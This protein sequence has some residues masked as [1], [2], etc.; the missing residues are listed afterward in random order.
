MHNIRTTIA[1]S[2]SQWK[3][4]TRTNSLNML[5]QSQSVDTINFPHHCGYRNI[6]NIGLSWFYFIHTQVR[7]FKW[8]KPRSK[9]RSEIR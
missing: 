5:R 7:V 3:L 6:K 1:H 9:Q 2:F 4:T 8:T